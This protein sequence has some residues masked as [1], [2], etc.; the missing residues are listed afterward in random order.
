MSAQD[1][2]SQ[3]QFPGY[4]RKRAERNRAAAAAE[5]QNTARDAARQARKDK[6]GAGPTVPASRDTHGW[7]VHPGTLGDYD[8]LVKPRDTQAKGRAGP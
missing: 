2:I 6:L 1:N 7:E 4:A 5:C 8:D 3:A